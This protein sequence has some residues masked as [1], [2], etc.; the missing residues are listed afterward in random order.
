MIIKA[1]I[2]AFIISP[3]FNAMYLRIILLPNTHLSSPWWPAFQYTL[4]MLVVGEAQVDCK[5]DFACN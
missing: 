2:A 1:A 4:S 3:P 5:E